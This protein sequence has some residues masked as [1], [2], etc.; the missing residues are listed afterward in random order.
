MSEG[1]PKDGP[2]KD[3]TK[4]GNSGNSGSNGTNAN[5]KP[6]YGP[7]SGFHGKPGKSGPPKGHGNA[8]RHG[9]SC[10]RLPK[11]ARYIEHRIN[12]LRRQLEEAVQQVRGKITLSDAANIQTALRW[13]RHSMLAQ[14]W[15]RVEG[16]KLAPME[17]LNFS[18]EICK[19]STERDKALTA[20]QLDR[21]ATTDIL[22]RLYRV[23]PTP[24]PGPK[25]EV[26]SDAKEQT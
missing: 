19:A 8:I 9:L 3:G 1:T 5:G 16:E 11:Q 20:L 17:R 26:E 14:R 23:V 12:S 7:G 24:L 15:L 4:G 22:D 21:D 2:P 10:G 25:P 13:E 6:R 18:R